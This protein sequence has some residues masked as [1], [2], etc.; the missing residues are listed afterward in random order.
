MP[1]RK[2]DTTGGFHPR[3]PSGPEITHPSIAAV[4][5]DGRL[6]RSILSP[7]LHRVLLGVARIRNAVSS[8]RMEGERVELDRARDLMESGEPE[9][10]SERG[11]VRLAKAYGELS[12]G[13][14]PEFTL[15]GIERS[16]RRLFAGTLDDGVV[17]RYKTVA[18][19][20]TDVSETIVRFH[21]TPPER[22]A[23][24]L[25]ALLEWVEGPG[26][27]GLPP[28]TA[29]IFLAEFESIHPFLDGNGRLGRFLN[30][31][32]LQ[33]LGLRNAALVPLDTRFFRTSD[34]YYEALAT[35]NLGTNYQLWT[36]YYVR[37][38]KKAYELAGR[39]GDLSKT[40]GR[41]SKPSTR[42]VAQWVLAGSGDW[43]HRGDY[44]NPRGYSGPALWGWLQ[45][46]VR[47]G[48]LEERGAAKGREYRIKSES[49]AEA[50]GRLA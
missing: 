34:H 8:F 5:L 38:L 20:I 22:V 44:P 10:P 24:E 27:A 29:A 9:T 1:S 31:A 40:V 30:V 46:L 35:T 14:L 4:R 11:V 13:Q 7:Q 15:S 50:Y 43:F 6:D 48:M 47:A 36:R 26:M 12:A 49:L 21:P 25:T 45:E 33:R 16:H 42:A 18:N 41:F 28:V 37:E 23:G 17:G 39:R 19:V 2:P 3:I 32:L